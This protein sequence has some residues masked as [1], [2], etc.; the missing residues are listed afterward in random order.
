MAVPE[1]ALPARA[2]VAAQ[3]VGAVREDVARPIFTLVVV[4]HVATLAA[5]A[6]VTVALAVQAGAVL[7]LPAGSVPAVACR[8]KDIQVKLGTIT[9]LKCQPIFMC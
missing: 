2:E 8:K 1:V 9:A 3:G 6:I 5:V 4:G 7:A